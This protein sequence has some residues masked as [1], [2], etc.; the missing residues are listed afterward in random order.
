MITVGTDYHNKYD[1]FGNKLEESAPDP[2]G[3]LGEYNDSQ[4]GNSS[5]MFVDPM[6]YATVELQIGVLNDER[7]IFGNV[8]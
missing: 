2:F 1:A 3:C 4:S 6:G 8:I 5:L 7:L